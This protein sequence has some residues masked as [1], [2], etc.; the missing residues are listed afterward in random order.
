MTGKT[1]HIASRHDLWPELSFDAWKDTYETLHLWTQIVGKIRLVLTPWTNHSWHV[2]LYVT[3]CGLSTSTVPYD[4]RSF[5]IEFDFHDHV[6]VILVND[7]SRKSIR[8]EPMSVAA[9]YRKLMAALDE[10]GLPVEINR[11]P[12]EIEDA[13]P[14]DQDHVHSSYDPDAAHRFG[15]VLAHCDR[16][17]STFRSRF[18]GKSSPVHF[19]WGSFD[20]ALTRFSGRPAPEHP[21]GIPNMPDWVAREAYS[22]EVISS[23]FWPGAGLG[24]AAFYTYAYPEPTGFRSAPLR[25]EEAY[26]HDGLSE[27]VLPYDAVR[28]ASDPDGVLMN[29]LQS[30]YEAAADL[31]RW[32]RAEL[33]WGEPP[34][35]QAS[36]RRKSDR[37]DG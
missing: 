14:F 11:T 12:N 35:W 28:M 36:P 8:L 10:L 21:G 6:L 19:F 37:A 1:P 9:F 34:P 32:N 5:Q 18:L 22:H 33:E 25:P 23:G 31:S 4:S 20:L 16:V 27:F 30:T 29:F 2:V 3:P 13:I 26:Y 15:Q 17:F 24:E 7:G